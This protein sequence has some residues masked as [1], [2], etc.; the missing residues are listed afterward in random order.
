MKKWL[1]LLAVVLLT[2]CSPGDPIT[3]LNEPM[4]FKGDVWTWNGTA[5]QLVNTNLGG[6]STSGV[7]Y[8]GAT[9]NVNLGTFSLTATGVTDSSLTNLNAVVLAGAGGA[10]T[11]TPNLVYQ[12]GYLSSNAVKVAAITT[13]QVVVAGIGAQSTLNGSTNM[14]FDVAT[15]VLSAQ[16]LSVAGTSN[17][18]GAATFGSAINMTS[19]KIT[20]LANGTASTDAINLSQL[21]TNTV[22]I[23]PVATLSS[24]ANQTSG[25]VTTAN[26]VTFNSNDL[27]SQITHSTS[28]N[29]SQVW[30]QSAGKYLITFSVMFDTALPNKHISI[31]LK[32]NGSNVANSG[33]D[34][35]ITPAVEEQLIT[36]TWIQDLLAGEYIE[37]AWWSDDAGCV[38]R[39]ELSTTA[40]TRPASPSVILTINKVSN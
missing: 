28:S 31:W 3:Q 30:T 27:L 1:V 36:V 32:K 6:N 2:G 38:L 5:Y 18:S 8:V 4:Y 39:A 40:P 23:W 24:T 26:N 21:T 34:K 25:G 35:S 11:S 14:T 37:V 9:Q 33:T 7:P 20:T 19:Q 16:N 10:L 17:I 15:G 22:T 29:T 13:G 12:A